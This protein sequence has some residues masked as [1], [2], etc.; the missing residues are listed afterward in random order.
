MK[1]RPM[2]YWE[3]DAEEVEMSIGADLG[4]S[5]AVEALREYNNKLRMSATEIYGPVSTLVLA[6][7]VILITGGVFAARPYTQLYECLS[8]YVAA[9]YYVAPAV[10]R[11]LTEGRIVRRWLNALGSELE[12]DA[13]GSTRQKL[14]WLRS[15]DR[16]IDMLMSKIDG[17]TPEVRTWAL[18]WF[19]K[20]SLEWSTSIR[21]LARWYLF[22]I[23]TGLALLVIA[24]VLSRLGFELASDISGISGIVLAAAEIVLSVLPGFSAA[25]HYGLLLSLWNVSH[26]HETGMGMV[27][28][29]TSIAVYKALASQSDAGCRYWMKRLLA[30]LLESVDPSQQRRLIDQHIRPYL[31]QWLGRKLPPSAESV[32]AGW[33]QV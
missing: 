21:L 5:E 23:P 28:R 24:S 7:C 18:P 14:E 20:P 6:A 27:S 17:E 33:Q 16:R 22:R 4:L 15:Y 10:T 31:E 1:G 8:V 32:L 13:V 2:R 25:E 26:L 9:V 30:E 19:R 29:R 3:V 12:A 11:L